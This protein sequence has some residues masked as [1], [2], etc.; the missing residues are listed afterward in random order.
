[1]FGLKAVPF[2][3]VAVSKNNTVEEYHI[4][5]PR[6]RYTFLLR[7]CDDCVKK[8]NLILENLDQFDDTTITHIEST[9]EI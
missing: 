1:M 8:L 5:L 3:F 2:G 9:G 4:M 7:S 6:R